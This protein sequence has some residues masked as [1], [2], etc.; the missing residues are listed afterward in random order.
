M[1]A[2]SAWIFFEDWVFF[3][4]G[5]WEREKKRMGIGADGADYH[6]HGLSGV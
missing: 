2:V 1:R 4:G 5:G 6:E 3:G